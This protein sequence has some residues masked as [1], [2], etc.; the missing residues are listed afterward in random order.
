M[1]EKPYRTSRY[2]IFCLSL[3][4]GIL[5]GSGCASQEDRDLDESDVGQ[6]L[7]GVAGAAAGSQV[8]EGSGQTVATIAGALIGAVIGERIGARMEDDDREYTAHA[9]E[10]NRTGET[11]SWE[12]P[13][14]GNEFWVTPTETFEDSGRPCR[15]FEF[16]VET[17]DG[18]DVQERTACRD[19]DGTWEVVGS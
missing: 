9:L 4:S 18:S 12:N 8:G 6:I 11:A 17:E 3:V 13:D 7:G 19:S 1:F 14:T 10:E 16:R 15:E 5:L 2:R